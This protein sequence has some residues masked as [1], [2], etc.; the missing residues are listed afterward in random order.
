MEET[1]VT[2]YNISFPENENGDNSERMKQTLTR[3]RMS[4]ML[5]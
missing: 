1:A 5:S 4:H 3:F 2:A